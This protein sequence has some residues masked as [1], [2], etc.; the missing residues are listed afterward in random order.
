[1][2]SLLLLLVLVP[3]AIALRWAGAGD[4][5]VFAASAGA[6]LPL[7]GLLGK[8]THELAI[9]TGPRVGAL[10]NVTLGNAAELII[11]IVAIREGLSELVKASI[12]GSILSN[13]LLVLGASLLA[14][15]L[16][17][18]RQ[19][20]DAHVAGIGSTMMTLAVVALVIPA[21]FDM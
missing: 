21:V 4:T 8:A 10:L 17:H 15:G 19:R 14:G 13:M 9:H 2:V 1:M 11:T 6:L 3:T 5:W 18:G 20:F 16:K 12:S 7:S